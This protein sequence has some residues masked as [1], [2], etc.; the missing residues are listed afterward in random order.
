MRE[1]DVHGVNLLL[2]NHKGGPTGFNVSLHFS[3]RL[4][5]I[6]QTLFSSLLIFN[7]CGEVKIR[8]KYL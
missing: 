1:T 4:M 6:A 2:F 8:I 7:D 5:L 3:R